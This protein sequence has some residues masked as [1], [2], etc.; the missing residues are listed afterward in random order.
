M[1][2]EAEEA[3]EAAEVHHLHLHQHRH[4]LLL[5]HPRLPPHLILFPI[6]LLV[7]RIVKLL[8]Y[9]P[10]WLLIK[11]F[12]RKQKS[13]ASSV[14]LLNARSSASSKSMAFPLWGAWDL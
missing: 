4:Q 7:R 1:G 5:Q 11:K 3:A 9:K 12:I 6:L 14:R 2:T 8:N 10:I 13:P